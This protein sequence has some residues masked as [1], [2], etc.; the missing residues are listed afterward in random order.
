MASYSDPGVLEFDAEI[1]RPDITGASSFVRFP[2]DAAQLFGVKGRVP[3]RAAFDGVE[4]RGSLTAQG[5]PQHLLLVLAEIQQ[6]IGKAPGDTVH[7]TVQLDTSER[8]VEIDD[9]IEKHLKDAGV[10]DAFR[11]MAYSHQREYV[12]WIMGAKQP[13]TR[14]RRIQKML[15]MV[16]EGEK[17]KR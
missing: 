15:G 16:A 6:R 3:V 17:L 2:F 8:V 13:E 5:G 12:L 14:E 11:A 10:F 1:W 4:Y 9:D 7:V